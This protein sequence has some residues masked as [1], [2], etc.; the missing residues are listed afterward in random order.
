[1]PAPRFHPFV[2][3][4]FC[5]IGLVGVSVLLGLLLYAGS[6]LS[7]PWTGRA[8]ATQLLD[9]VT[10]LALPLTVLS[11]P[12][13]LLWMG[14]CRRKFDGCSFVSLGLRPRRAGANMVRGILTG[15]L[16]IGFLWLVLWL[17]GTISV[18]GWSSS[19]LENGVLPAIGA[20]F[21]YALAFFA[22][23]FFEETLFRGTILHN[24][25]AWLGWRGAV[26]LQAVLFALIHLG[27][28][29]ST[30]NE[31]KMAAIGALPSL[32]LIAV[33]FALSYRKTGSLWFPIGFHFAWN[34][35]LGC[36]FSLPVS[37]IETFK[38]LDVQTTQNSWFSG[39]S[40]GAEGSF[41]LI[42]I[43]IALIY[44]VSKAPDHPQ[45]LLDL[46]LPSRGA[47]AIAPLQISTDSETEMSE[48]ARE[49][50]YSTKFGTSQG[51]S[52][53]TLRELRELQ[54][55]REKAQREAVEAARREALVTS[56]FAPSIVVEVAPQIIKVDAE[57]FDSTKNEAAEL[58]EVQS[59]PK[60]VVEPKAAPAPEIS[61]D[62][63]PPVK[64][65]PPAPRW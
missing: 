62:S 46:Q 32:F 13:S 61:T 28:V 44:T 39:G 22:V 53:D 56:S 24:L 10:R 2:R 55:E 49:S 57:N 26:A 30:N 59:A 54:E 47:E 58:P 25:N 36:V 35:C 6:A 9:L 40:F 21:G 52:A 1:M 23:G 60:I 50:R 51:F 33:F 18:A 34:F 8:P 14:V 19:V 48:E 11:Y 16:S 65:K 37:G 3:L 29:N 45:A 31:S 20:L 42:P 27:N 5:G 7:T 63:A 38:L 12:A 4:I 41:Y 64:K 43:L 17:T 15:A